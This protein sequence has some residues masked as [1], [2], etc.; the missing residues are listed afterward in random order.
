M[1]QGGNATVYVSDFEAALGFYTRVLGLKLR[2]RAGT[3]WAEVDAGRGFVIGIHPETPHSPKPGTPGAIQIGLNVVEP[4][5]EVM[6]RLS[7]S[8]VVFTSALISGGE[9]GRFVNLKDLDGNAI[10]L[11]ESPT[12]A[13]KA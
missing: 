11:W 10:Y 13:R 6:R 3:N 4:L 5:D 9:A 1:I 12:A 7:K 2:F 8:G